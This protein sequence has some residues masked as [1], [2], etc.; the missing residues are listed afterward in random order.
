M[1]FTRGCF[2]VGPE[3]PQGIPGIDG[4]DGATGPQGPQG[5]PG[6][7]PV[8]QVYSP[9]LVIPGGTDPQWVTRSARFCVAGGMCWYQ[10][11]FSGDGGTEG[12]GANNARLS[13]P[14][15]S[16][17]SQLNNIIVPAGSYGGYE[18]GF[19]V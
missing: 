19:Q 9:T 11:L 18:A 16:G 2:T 15:N 8:W 1:A 12:S 4:A 5:D 10:G 17:A 6:P 3:G 14:F 13:L 7:S